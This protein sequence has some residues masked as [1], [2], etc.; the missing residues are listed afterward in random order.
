MKVS[1]YHRPLYA[2]WLYFSLKIK[3]NLLF[4]VKM[5]PFK[6]FLNFN[7]S[8]NMKTIHWA[9]TLCKGEFYLKENKIFEDDDSY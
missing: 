4:Y 7:S 2:T 5:F 3:Q 8:L 6:K 1:F 9:Y